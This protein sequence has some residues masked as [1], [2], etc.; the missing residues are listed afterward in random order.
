MV[1]L[2][3]SLHMLLQIQVYMICTFVGKNSCKTKY[4]VEFHLL[5]YTISR[6]F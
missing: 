2:K 6:Q 1:E 4:P 5:G 3:Y